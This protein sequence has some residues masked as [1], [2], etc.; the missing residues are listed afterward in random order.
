VRNRFKSRNL[1]VIYA[2]LNTIAPQEFPRVYPLVLRPLAFASSVQSSM[3]PGTMEHFQLM[4]SGTDPAVGLRFV[5]PDGLVFADAL[6]AQ[7]GV[8]RLP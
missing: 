4:A 3:Y 5:R 2:R 8:F 6:K 1:R 7:L